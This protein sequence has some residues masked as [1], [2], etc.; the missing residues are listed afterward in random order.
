MRILYNQSE[1][2]PVW[3]TEILYQQQIGHPVDKVEIPEA[4]NKISVTAAGILKDA[5]QKKLQTEEAKGF[6]RSLVFFMYRTDKEYR[7]S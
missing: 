5:P 6:L 2:A 4:Y 7:C 1:I 3:E